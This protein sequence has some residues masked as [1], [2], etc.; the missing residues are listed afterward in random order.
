V[1]PFSNAQFAN[2]LAAFK[3][4]QSYTGIFRDTVFDLSSLDTVV[5]VSGQVAGGVTCIDC[6]TFTDA[7]I[8]DSGS[9]FVH[10][11][12]SINYTVTDS[13][14]TG[15]TGAK[16][17][18]YDTDG[19][20]QGAIQTSS[21]GNVG[22]IVA[23]F[24]KWQNSSP[25]ANKAPFDIRIRKYGYQYQGF[26]SSVSEPIK[27]EF[28]LPVNNDLVSTEA[29]ASAITGISFDF[30]TE[31]IT[32]TSDTD[33]QELYD[34][35]QYQLAQTANMQYGEDL[36]RIGDSFNIDD[37][38]L[39]LDGCTYTGSITTTGSATFLNS[40]ILVGTITDSSGTT[41]RTELNLTGLQANTE[42]RIYTAGTTTELAGVENSTTSFTTTLVESSV[43]IVIH[44]LGY[45]YQKLSSVDTS[46]N[47]SLPVTQ[48]IDR[49]Y[50]NE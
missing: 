42:I 45:E 13:N 4:F 37:W 47:L 28:R 21:S 11:A 39:V 23:T 5:F 17:A 7:D 48:R 19:T 20:L 15:L 35:Y 10:Q 24:F 9:G 18:V 8:T 14:G 44:A 29:Q 27:Q 22:E 16:V 25:S 36:I 3:T 34:Y 49:N 50:R 12:K 33:T 46:Q 38:D 1:R 32:I 30:S 26:Q 40:A 31:T 43:D 41:T 2:G 6:T